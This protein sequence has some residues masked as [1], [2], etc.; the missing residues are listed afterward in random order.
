MRHSQKAEEKA[1]TRTIL[2]GQR[3]EYNRDGNFI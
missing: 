2:A 3:A 1:V